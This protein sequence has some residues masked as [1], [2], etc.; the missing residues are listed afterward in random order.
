MSRNPVSRCLY[1]ALLV[2]VLLISGCG[3]D[4]TSPSSKEEFSFELAVVDRSG[5]PLP[6][7]TVSRVCSIEYEILTSGMEAVAQSERA[8]EGAATVTAIRSAPGAAPPAEFIL[9][10]AKPNPGIT[11][12]MITLDI[13]VN[14]DTRFRIFNWKG[15]ELWGSSNQA[16]GPGWM[17]VG[18]NFSSGRTI[19]EP[20]GIFRCEFTSTEPS[21]SSLLFQDHIYFSGLTENDPYRT[22]MGLTD[23]DGS[24]RTT[25]KGYFPSLQGH[26]PQMGHDS[27]GNEVAPFSFSDIVAFR[28]Q[29]APPPG[30]GEYKIYWM[31]MD[32]VIS[33]G[34]NVFEWVFIPE[35]STTVPAR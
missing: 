25:D 19:Y 30:G 10:P 13:P 4:S 15:D 28:V 21:D 32:A 9:N 17:S 12:S 27:D 6:D 7:L 31:T 20:N 24:F 11:Q 3:D 1:V 35:D 16:F 34:S 33:G 14:C 18:Y 29:T 26:Q 2:S 23:A 8:G 5:A 22:S